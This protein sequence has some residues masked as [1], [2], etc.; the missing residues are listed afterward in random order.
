MF[1]HL[2][3][4][5]H[6]ELQTHLPKILLQVLNSQVL[7]DDQSKLSDIL[8]QVKFFAPTRITKFN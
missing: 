1:N 3:Q 6:N 7:L 8:Y 4:K 5:N 2:F